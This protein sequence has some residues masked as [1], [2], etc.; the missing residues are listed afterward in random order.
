[1]PFCAGC[2]ACSGGT[3]VRRARAE[4]PF[5]LTADSNPIKSSIRHTPTHVP[6]AEW[7]CGGRAKRACGSV[8]SPVDPGAE[9]ARVPLRGACAAAG[10]MR[11][12]G[13]PSSARSLAPS[14][15]ART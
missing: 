1:M 4:N 7:N 5:A 10:N 8:F 12:R 15:R 3:P 14:A 6:S 9:D 11:V 2:W 13:P